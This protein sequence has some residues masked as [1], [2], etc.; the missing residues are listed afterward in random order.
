MKPWLVVLALLAVGPSGRLAAQT[1]ARLIE[2]LRLAQNGQVDSGRSVI[3]RLLSALPPS[4]SV[5]PQALLAGAK[6]APDAATVATNLNRIVLEYGSSPWA[7]DAL[8]LLTQLYFAQRDAAQTI[9]AAERLRQNY[10]D[11]PLRYRADFPAARAYFELKNEAR[12]CEL[13]QESL[14]GANAAGEVEFTNQVNF[15]ASRCAGVVTAPPPPPAADSTAPAAPKSYTV[16][17]LAVKS[18]V[19][20][21]EM[22]TRLKVMGFDARV[23][24]DTSGFFKVRVGRYNTREEAHQTQQR[25]RTR[26]GGQAFVV[27]EP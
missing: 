14:A 12:G 5:Y 15:Y 27:E 21:D 13:I 24:R 20:V 8:L 19:Q 18:A 17:V 11:S 6:I 10:P 23:V 7:D 25:L 22:L 3:R 26:L 4:D 2:A 16:Q 1:D 9:Q